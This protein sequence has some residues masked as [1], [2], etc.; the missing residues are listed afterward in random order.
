M[1][2]KV[3]AAILVS[4]GT[5][6][7]VLA[8][9]PPATTPV[10]PANGLVTSE[11]HIN[12]AWN[13]AGSNVTGYDMFL[14][15]NGATATVPCLNSPSP[16][17]SLTLT[18]AH[19]EWFVRNYTAGCSAGTSSAH[20]T[21][22]IVGCSTPVAPATLTPDGGSDTSAVVTLSWSGGSADTW[23]VYLE[24]GSSC[25]TTTPLNPAPLPTASTSFVTGT[26]VRGATYAWR[27]RASRGSTCPSP[28]FSHCATFKVR[29]CDPPPAPALSQPQDGATG[30]PAITTLTW[31]A[32]AGAAGYNVW[33]RTDGGQPFALAGTTTSTSLNA[34]FPPGAHVEW[35]VDALNGTC[36]TSSAHRTFTTASCGTAVP[37]ALSPT[38]TTTAGAPIVFRWSAVSGAGLYRLWLAPAGG[39]FTSIEETSD[40]TFTAHRP[41][42]AYDWYVEA[43]GSDCPSTRSA[44][45][46]FT[47]PQAANCAANPPQLQTPANGAN[48][49]SAPLQLTWT[50]V[51]NA[52]RYEVWASLGN[53]A[54]ARIA[55]TTG[56]SLNTDLAPGHITWYVVALR[57]GC[58]SLPSATST[59]DVTRA[60]ACGTLSAPLLLAP[61]D[62]AEQVPTTVDFF[63]TNVAGAQ[64]Y[65]LW[66][67]VDDGPASVLAATTGLR[68]Q[69]TVPRGRIR[70]FVEANFGT[71]GS[72]R[73]ASSS[74]R[75]NAS[76]SC[77]SPAA[78]SISAPA[79]IATGV[80]YN[81]HWNAQPNVARYEILESTDATAATPTILS[82]TDVTLSLSHNVAAA[83]RFHYRVR[84]VNNC[85]GGTGPLSADASVLVAPSSTVV[86][87][88]NGAPFVQTLF[89]PGRGAAVAFTATSDQ[90]WLTIT[91]SSGTLPPE[92]ITLTL[93]ADLSSL[94]AG[95]SVA[96]VRIDTPASSG[97]LSASGTTSSTPVSVTLVTPSTPGGK[98]SAASS[99]VI[100]PAVAHVDGAATFHSDVRLANTG[101]RPQR[102]QL[103]FT[104]SGTDATL[105][106]Q[107]TFLQVES[108][109][110]I[111]LNDLLQSFFGAAGTSTAG[112]LEIK[113]VTATS[114]T[115]P[116]GSGPVSVTTFASSRTF[117][118]TPNGTS[119]QFIPALP[120]SRF[121]GSN[122][123][124]LVPQ[125]S[126]AGA[127]RTN[128]GLVEASAQP[129]HVVLDFF[130]ALGTRIGSVPVDLLAGEHQQLNGIVT[131]T[132][133]LAAATRMQLNVTS[134][135]GLVTAYASVLDQQTSDPM[136][137][138]AV[139]VNGGGAKKYVVPGVAS[140]DAGGGNHW[141]SDVRIFNGAASAQDATVTFTPQGSS[142]PLQ[143]VPLSLSPGET[144]KL[145]D[146]LRATFGTDSASGS[147]TVSTP[148][149]STLAV[150]ARTYFDTSAGTYGQFIPA[151]TETS[152]TGPGE[153][154]QQI[155]QAEQSDHYRTNLGLVELSGQPAQVEVTAFI[156][157]SKVQP[158]V[159]LSLGP[160]Q[161]VQYGSILTQLG[162]PNVYNARLAFRVV[163]STGRV[164]GYGCLIDNTSGDPTYVPS[165]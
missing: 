75:S 106:A 33:A 103:T 99:A 80:P 19:Y 18:P 148:A 145:D 4:L 87:F 159:T 112:A 117:T 116:S 137:V 134:T 146:I 30:L 46:R 97:K 77:A 29:V 24:Q 158:V 51:P 72:R 101:P 21:F 120:L 154:A 94:N 14:S 150:T 38:G 135:T 142:T 96:N 102:Y 32:S 143:S 69:A 165:Q 71:C 36:T 108:G 74:F 20:F 88:G 156:P 105:S 86:P 64:D 55:E 92:G 12:F 11:T 79:S 119:G 67:A 128:V 132:N 34:S 125:V 31:G 53:A 50:A 155:L 45:T 44:T 121:A 76:S 66:V 68:S 5:S 9:C 164:A 35:Y 17:C 104:P 10:L 118:V 84:A 122:N 98:S 91:P 107:Q 58:N 60:A 93:T 16:N 138:D 2:R 162:L 56:T 149:L 144:R 113:P 89:V 15:Q 42:G 151:L 110:T 124:L 47:V 78:P 7:A 157:D 48:V 160:N 39:A 57:D 139:A 41:A 127:F 13:P 114:D 49:T 8:Q 141:R 62:A 61:A 85:G 126:Q 43:I 163:S 65:K 131:S 70:W 152:G 123:A 59:F 52:T 95:D 111:A 115:T 40:T 22:D 129:A 130:N 73:S 136:L 90:T 54:P 83:T 140:L 6:A 1:M 153:R 100:L 63:W 27:V 161:Y 147:I 133:A 25:A 81:L 26:L 109:A 3:L 28:V 82:S 23:D 37:T